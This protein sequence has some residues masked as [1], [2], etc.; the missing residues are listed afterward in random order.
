MIQSDPLSSKGQ[1]TLNNFRAIY[2]FGAVTSQRH[3]RATVT[4]VLYSCYGVSF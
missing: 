1:N 3:S 4:V 2:I